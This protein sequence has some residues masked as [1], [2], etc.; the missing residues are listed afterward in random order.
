MSTNTLT[1]PASGEAPFLDRVLAPMPIVA[2]STD[3]ENPCYIVQQAGII[4]AVKYIPAGAKTGDNTNYRTLSIYNRGA[5]NAGTAL[6][7][8]LALTTGTNLAANTPSTLALSGTP[9]NLVVAVGD[10]LTFSSVHTAS[11]LSDPGGLLVIDIGR[12]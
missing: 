12:N 1:A 7:A 8:T 10:V 2:I 11:G 3:A 9:A 4:Q 5:A 6:A